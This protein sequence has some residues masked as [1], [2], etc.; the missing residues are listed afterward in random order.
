M[1]KQSAKQSSPQRDGIKPAASRSYA[2]M[3]SRKT[4][5]VFVAAFSVVA[6]VKPMGLLLWARLRILT[7]IPKTAIADDPAKGPVEPEKPKDIDPGLSGGSAGLMDPFRVD[8]YR[9]PNPNVAPQ[10]GASITPSS[11]PQVVPAEVDALVASEGARR[12]AERFRL[13][14]AGRG[15]TMAVIDGRTYQV[16]DTLKSVDGFDFVLVE[17]LESAA[18][19]GRGAER[20]EI[21]M[22][23]AAVGTTTAKTTGT[24]PRN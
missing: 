11:K 15:L 7:S 3:R 10:S 12:A 20:F 22:R 21:S 16:G 14:S 2:W 1:K 5:L 17:V 23:G 9:F 19:I 8:P 13:Q 24:P 18:V 6:W 4:A